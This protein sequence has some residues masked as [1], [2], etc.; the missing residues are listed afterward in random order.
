MIKRFINSILAEENKSLS[1]ALANI[2]N[3]KDEVLSD[4]DSK[5][6]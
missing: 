3:E 5:A 2:T 6:R 4:L 1:K